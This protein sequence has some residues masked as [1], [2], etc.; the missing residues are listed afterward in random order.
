MP[1]P[2]PLQTT[3]AHLA[4]AV[5]REHGFALAGGHALIAHGIVDRPTDDVDLFTD[6]DD[7]VAA[8]AGLIAVALTG[9]GLTVEEVPELG[10][11]FDGFDRDMVEFEVSHGEHVVRLQLARFD[12]R[13]RPVLMDIGPVLHLDDVVSTKVAALVTRAYPRDFV[14]IAAAAGRYPRQR[15]IELGRRADPALTDGE[16]A[17]AVRRLDRLDDSVFA[18]L[19]GLGPDQIADIRAAFADWPRA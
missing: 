5:A 17:D 6:R 12:R 15:L 14:D 10:D 8:A 3:V 2:D 1:A 7:G 11:M 13:Q 18:E 4:L 9:S 16:F 19:Y